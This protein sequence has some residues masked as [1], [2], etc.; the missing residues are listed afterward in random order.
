MFKL[1][2][3]R[4]TKIHRY[5]LLLDTKEPYFIVIRFRI[6]YGKG[7]VF[8][9]FIL[10]PHCPFIVIFYEILATSSFVIQDTKSCGDYYIS[11]NAQL[12][13]CAQDIL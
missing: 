7:S 11:E 2:Y 12:V 9:S 6:R 8:R 10:S 13:K 5:T 1:G 4:Y 3:L